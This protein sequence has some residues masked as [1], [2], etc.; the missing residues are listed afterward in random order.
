TSE[1]LKVEGTFLK[2]RNAIVRNRADV[3]AAMPAIDAFL[4]LA[5]EDR[6][7]GSLLA[8]AVSGTRD[9]AKRAAL[10]E[11]L[12]KEFPKSSQAVMLLGDRKRREAVGKP[13]EL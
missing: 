4:K 12:L 10:E 11:R 2:A 8:A 6:R 7:S 1:K 3:E 5:P 9:E 13:F